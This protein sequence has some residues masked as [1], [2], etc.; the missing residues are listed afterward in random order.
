MVDVVNEVFQLTSSFANES[1]HV[2]AEPV[3]HVHIG[4]MVRKL[5]TNPFQTVS[6][7]AQ[8]LSDI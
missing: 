6:Q 5:L 2:F 7:F 1:P 8:L 3:C 4:E